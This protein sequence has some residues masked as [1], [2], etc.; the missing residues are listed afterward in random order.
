MQ[1]ST[2]SERLQ[3][4]KIIHHQ[5]LNFVILSNSVFFLQDLYVFVHVHSLDQLLY[6][7][8]ALEEAELCMSY[9]IHDGMFSSVFW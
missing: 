6:L 2:Q 8:M 4:Y 9:Y 5:K 3:T 7:L 1:Q